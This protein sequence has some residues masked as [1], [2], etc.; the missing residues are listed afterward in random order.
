[1]KKT[2]LAISTIVSALCTLQTSHAHAETICRA[3]NAKNHYAIVQT[4]GFDLD[5]SKAF[6]IDMLDH[7]KRVEGE[8]RF[9]G[10]QDESLNIDIK[11]YTMKICMPVNTNLL[12]SMS[13]IFHHRVL[14]SSKCLVELFTRTDVKL[15][16][17]DLL[18]ATNMN[19]SKFKGVKIQ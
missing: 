13:F 14:T 8:V 11:F 19:V 18:I 5:T 12:N 3:T 15:I 1:M 4:F 7:D 17:S 9:E 10:P 6:Y 2:I 16:C